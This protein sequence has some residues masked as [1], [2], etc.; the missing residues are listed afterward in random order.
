MVR[1]PAGNL[2]EYDLARLE[3]HAVDLYTRANPS[4]EHRKLHGSVSRGPDKV[5]LA[6]CAVI[7]RDNGHEVYELTPV[8]EAGDSY[9][10]M[11]GKHPYG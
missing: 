4:D 3:S 1:Y 2:V 10:A 9:E 7:M 11:V 8:L 5:R 6:A